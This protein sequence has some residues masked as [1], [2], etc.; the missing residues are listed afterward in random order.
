MDM[1]QQNRDFFD[2]AAS[3]YS[4]D[5]WRHDENQV[6]TTYFTKP[7]A[8]L[9]VLGC[10][11][12]RTLRPLRDLGFQITAIDIS[13][14][15]IELARQKFSAYNMKIKQADARNLPFNNDSFAYAFF[16]FHGLDSVADRYQALNEAKRVLEPGGILIFSSH[17]LLFPRALKKILTHKWRK[18]Y[19]Q[20]A[21]PG[22]L[23]W[24]YHTTV[25]ERNRLGK[26]FKRVIAKPRIRLQRITNWKAFLLHRL[27]YFDKSLYFICFN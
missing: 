4:R 19:I 12:G 20:L 17:N 11:A 23:V 2:R 13:E 10:G 9:L 3:Y 7:N 22:G 21:E 6:V 5:Y 27:P 14:K 18:K 24:T 15:M 25:L 8:K 26:I 1:Q 16:P